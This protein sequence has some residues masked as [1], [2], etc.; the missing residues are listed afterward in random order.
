MKHCECCGKDIADKYYVCSIDCTNTL[1]MERGRKQVELE[2]ANH[3]MVF[4]YF[5][6][7]SVDNDSE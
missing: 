7:P 1:A 3:T 2:T 6:S 4:D 5:K